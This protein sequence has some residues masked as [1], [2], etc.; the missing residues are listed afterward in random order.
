MSKKL[1]ENQSVRNNPRKSVHKKAVTTKEVRN[2]D[3]K[4]SGVVAQAGGPN[5]GSAL[6]ANILVAGATLLMSLVC[7]LLVWMVI[8]SRTEVIA[9]TEDGRLSHPVPLSQSFVTESR[10]LGFVDECLR[11]S[12]SHDFENYRRTFRS[13]LP[14]YTSLGGREFAKAI[15]PLLMDIREKR[16]IMSATAEPPALR[17]GPVVVNGRAMWEVQTIITLYFQGTRERFS[18]QRR[19]ATITVVRVPLGESPRGVAINAIQ[20]GPAPAGQ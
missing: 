1:D 3:V 12:F 16:I 7:V 11:A 4:S 19:L 15:D 9:T 8:S 14:C 6:K 5:V 20:L 17:R 13:A 18:P 10:V 2:K